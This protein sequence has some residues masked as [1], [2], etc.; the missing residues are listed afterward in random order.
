MQWEMNKEYHMSWGGLK[1]N[2]QY[3]WGMPELIWKSSGW[4][5]YYHRTPSRLPLWLSWQRICLQCG[6]PEFDPRIGKIP[7]RRKRQP[8]PVLLPGEFYDGAVGQAAVQESQSRTC[9]T[10]F[11]SHIPT[12]KFFVQCFISSKQIK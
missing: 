10:N 3:L 4:N 1:P 5:S 2:F 7:W 8:T 6:S 12:T 9:A 11:L